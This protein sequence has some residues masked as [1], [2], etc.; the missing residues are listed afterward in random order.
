MDSAK[1]IAFHIIENMLHNGATMLLLKQKFK[2]LGKIT[3][4][5]YNF[6]KNGIKLSDHISSVIGIEI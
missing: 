6:K 2:D 4:Q 1:R 3:I 5:C